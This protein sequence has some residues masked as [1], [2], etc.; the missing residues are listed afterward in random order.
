MAKEKVKEKQ[1]E[2]I[3][4]IT[5]VSINDKRVLIKYDVPNEAGVD[6][7]TLECAE[8]PVPDFMT[9]FND[10]TKHMPK[11]LALPDDWDLAAYVAELIIKH[12]G[13]YFSAAFK[14]VKEVKNCLSPLKLATPLKWN[15]ESEDD[16]P[17]E[18][19]CI[20]HGDVLL[21]INICLKHAEAYIKGTRQQGK[22]FD[23]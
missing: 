22:L 2:V 4:R 8:Q 13:E 5:K 18:K 1:M 16:S 11:W 10:L 6:S 21:A 17:Y 3:R 14:I 9:A 23:G 20:M 7:Y 15:K 19:E 12:D